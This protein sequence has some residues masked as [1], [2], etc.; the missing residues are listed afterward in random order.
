MNKVKYY[1]FEIVKDCGTYRTVVDDMDIKYMGC[2]N[3]LCPSRYN[4]NIVCFWEGELKI[5]LYINSQHV[6]LNDHDKFNNIWTTLTI[7][8]KIYIIRGTGV[9]IE[10]NKT[11]LLTERREIS[12][13]KNGSTFTI[14]YATNPSTG[15]SPQIKFS[16]GLSLLDEH[17]G[18]ECDKSSRGC[19]GAILYTF[20]S[21]LVGLQ[22]IQLQNIRQWEKTNN[23]EITNFYILII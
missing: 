12:Q 22:S 16:S 9:R 5:E 3:S 11:Y 8:E 13:F 18:S 7:N 15:Y 20:K 10:D 21:N 6:I 19:G 4:K 17:Y 23:S 1:D 14:K 2:Q